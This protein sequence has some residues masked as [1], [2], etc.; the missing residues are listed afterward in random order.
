MFYWIIRRDTL[1]PVK[2]KARKEERCTVTVNNMNFAA[3]KVRVR[4]SGLRS[5]FWHGDYWFRRD[6]GLLL[7]YKG[8]TG[9]PGT[10]E[11]TVSILADSLRE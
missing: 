6:D 3:R 10:P 2:M 7:R 5:L 4:L 9:P 8:T 1:T 11:K